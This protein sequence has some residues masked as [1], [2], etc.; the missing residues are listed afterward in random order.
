MIN[1]AGATGHLS[2]SPP[3]F[4]EGV[5][6][7]NAAS[8]F[9]DPNKE[10]GEKRYIRTAGETVKRNQGKVENDSPSAYLIEIRS[11][12]T[13]TNLQ[14]VTKLLN[15]V[16]VVV[17]PHPTYNN[18]QFVFTCGSIASLTVDEIK[19]NLE[20]DNVTDVYRFTRK[21]DG[22][23]VP[24]N[25]YVVTMQAVNPRTH[26]HWHGVHQ[27]SRLLS[28]SNALQHVFAVRPHQKQLK[29]WRNLRN[30]WLKDPWSVH[31][32]FKMHKLRWSTQ[33]FRY[34]LSQIQARSSA[35]KTENRPQLLL[36]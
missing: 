12:H 26:L 34:Q 27:D 11:E 16:E 29:K 17:E 35:D 6:G 1:D 25:S 18:V 20:E 7:K 4:W 10:H 13:Y 5:K 23:S 19:A 22:K 14:T 30:V 9:M 28:T 15:N 31:T 8:F 21:S 3:A 36:P 33:C 2:W 24:T 32:A